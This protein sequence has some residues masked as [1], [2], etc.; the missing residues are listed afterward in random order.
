MREIKFRGFAFFEKEIGFNIRVSSSGYSDMHYTHEE[1]EYM[2]INQVDK[3]P[4]FALM[5]Y[6]GLKDKNGIEIYEGDILKLDLIH[7]PCGIKEPIKDSEISAVYWD[8]IEM[9][10]RNKFN[11]AGNFKYAEII[12][13]IHQ[14][15]EL[16]Q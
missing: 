10:F 16:I 13:N 11:Y 15:P 1:R 6:T 9:R 4:E 12:G 8:N 2:A 3:K 7:H 14:N 5:Q